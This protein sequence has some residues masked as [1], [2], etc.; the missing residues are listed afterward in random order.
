MNAPTPPIATEEQVTKS[1]LEQQ[2]YNVIGH[3]GNGSFAKVK[4]ATSSKE[5]KVVAIK[6]ISK[7]KTPSDYL[8]KFLPREIDVVRG[9]EHPN[10]IKYFRCIETTRRVYIVMQFAENGS[11][12]DLIRRRS[13]LPEN[14]SRVIYKQL[15]S[16]L[17]YCHRNGIVHRDIKCENL[18]F[19]SENVLK[20]I[21]FGFARRYLPLKS[22][23]DEGFS[24]SRVGVQQ[25]TAEVPKRQLSE[26]YCGSYAYACPEILIGEPYDPR[27]ADIWASGVV[28]FAMVFGRLPFDDAD[29]S[30][31]VKQ[32]YEKI[33]FSTKGLS[34][35]SDLC[36]LCIQRIVSTRAKPLLQTIKEDPWMMITDDN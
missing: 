31:L 25:T 36:K 9:L 1:I 32:V 26:T 29:F 30:K 24:T 33:N 10:I 21:D 16:A 19:D 23:G 17:E 8:T 20:L 2:G 22:S 3:I 28:L 14:E 13:Q 27:H 11:L 12:L 7:A 6:F 15:L 18:L 35:V 5:K 4:K 34:P